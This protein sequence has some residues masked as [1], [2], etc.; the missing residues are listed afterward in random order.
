MMT[1]TGDNNGCYRIFLLYPIV[2]YSFSCIST[3]FSIF[4]YLS[5]FYISYFL[6]LVNSCVDARIDLSDLL[7]KFSP[8]LPSRNAKA[9]IDAL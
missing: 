8:L 1:R 3:K 5:Q 9:V 6:L 4:S 2:S 7:R